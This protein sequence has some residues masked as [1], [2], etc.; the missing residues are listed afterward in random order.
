MRN[1]APKVAKVV[2]RSKLDETQLKIY[3]SLLMED[4]VLGLQ[5][6]DQ[7]TVLSVK[8]TV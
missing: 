2:A 7:L 3:S 8:V 6:N 5:D 4:L 1:S